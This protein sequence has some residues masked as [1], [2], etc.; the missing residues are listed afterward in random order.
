VASGR[1]GYFGGKLKRLTTG[2]L[3]GATVCWLLTCAAAW[4]NHNTTELVSVGPNGGNGAF[5]SQ[6]RGA[7]A[8]GNRVMI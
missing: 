3:T 6:W 5:S 1:R 4:G 2:A 8:D 7:S